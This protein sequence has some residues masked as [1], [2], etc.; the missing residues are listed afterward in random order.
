MLNSKLLTLLQQSLFL[1]LL[2]V[3]CR[4]TDR[5]NFNYTSEIQLPP[6]NQMLYSD[7][8]YLPYLRIKMYEEHRKIL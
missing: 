3:K 5:K 8:V 4:S 2:L 7:L 6:W 1:C